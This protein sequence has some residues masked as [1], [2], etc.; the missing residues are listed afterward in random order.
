MTRD[1]NVPSSGSVLVTLAKLTFVRLQRGKMLWV[2]LAIAFLPIMFTTQLRDK[3]HLISTAFVIELL[4]LAVVPPLFVASSIGDEIED[5]TT[6]YLWS[7][8]L[9][10]WT[11]LAGKLLALAPFSMAVIV[12][13]WIAAIQLGAHALP[14]PETMVG[15]AAGA[16]AISMIATGI[17]TLVPKQGMALTIVYVL[18]FDLPVGEIPASVRMVSVT[19]A[20]SAIAGL[21]QDTTALSG[22]VAMAVIAG[23]WI[24]LAFRRI[25]RLEA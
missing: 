3:T 14:P 11:V 9:A 2:S 17:A 15:L 12:A 24:A 16:L 18:F 5:R 10:R 6:T 7:R 22:V 1:E 4:V 21:E 25:R 8:P 13:S 20:A 19:H 23:L